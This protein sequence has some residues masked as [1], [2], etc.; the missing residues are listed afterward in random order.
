MRRLDGPGTHRSLCDRSETRH[1][2]A[3]SAVA[4]QA[5]VQGIVLIQTVRTTG[6]KGPFCR[7]DCRHRGDEAKESALRLPTDCRSGELGFR[8]PRGQT[9][10]AA[11]AGQA[12]PARPRLRG[13]ILADISRSQ[14][15]QSLERR[16]VGCEFLLDTQ[17]ALN[18]SSH[19]YVQVAIAFFPRRRTC[20]GRGTVCPG[21]TISS[22][23]RAVWPTP[24]ASPAWPRP[25]PRTRSCLRPEKST[26]ASPTWP[27]CT[28]R[29]RARPPFSRQPR[30]SDARWRCRAAESSETRCR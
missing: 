23:S 1:D 13:S 18:R 22:N 7:V 16:P 30:Q 29:S 6:A 24:A 4:G 26:G 11:R 15:G 9:P 21:H 20:F 3:V 19:P 8:C 2:T 25:R 28:A 27:G 14:Q 5:Q 17:L 10:G 12:L